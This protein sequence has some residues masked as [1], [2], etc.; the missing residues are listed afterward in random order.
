VG[1][2]VSYE[3]RRSLRGRF[4]LA[5]L[6]IVALI[7]VVIF[8][9]QRIWDRAVGGPPTRRSH[10]AAPTGP[11]TQGTPATAVTLT[12]TVTAP[13]CQVFVRVP[14]GDILVDRDLQ[15]GQTVRLDEQRL[16]VVLGDAAAARVYVNGHLRP[17]GEP[18][19]RAEFIAQKG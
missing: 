16:S 18:G 4:S 11:G 19:R 12:L 8:A 3:R 15:R 14:G 5:L 7:G 9:G 13:R 1:R 17:A 2:H 10:A 6:A